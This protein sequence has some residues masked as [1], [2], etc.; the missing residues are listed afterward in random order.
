MPSIR[1]DR[2]YNLG[3]LQNKQNNLVQLIFDIIIYYM[4]EFKK[5]IRGMRVQNEIDIIRYV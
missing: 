4:S 1:R 5:Y 3:V 2:I